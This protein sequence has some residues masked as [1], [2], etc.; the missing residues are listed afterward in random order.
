MVKVF[1]ILDGVG[2]KACRVLNGKTPLE[3]AKTKNLDFFASNGN[4]GFVYAI[5]ET[6]APESDE[7]ILALLGYDPL[8]YYYGRGPLEAYGAGLKFDEGDLV[9]R[10]NF[11]TVENGS[12]IVD[13]R[14][15]RSLTTAEA[16]ELEK[17]I[18]EKVKI[19]VP[20]YFKATIGHRGVLVL[21]GDFSD[22]ITNVDPAY[23]KK[24]KFG[25]AVTNPGNKVL[26]A[27]PL[28]P[29]KKTKM[30]ARVV[31]EFVKQSYEVL[32]D[33]PIN[34]RRKKRYL[35]P[36]NILLPRDA[37]TFLPELEARTGWT[38]V[39]AMPLEI[40]IT[41]LSGMHVL[42]FE[43]PE[44]KNNDVYAHLKKGLKLT[45]KES[46]NAIKERKFEKYFIH[47]KETDIPGHD[48][49]AKEKKKYIEMIDKKFFKYL[50]N[51]PN[52]ELVVTGDHSTPCEMK[53]H[54]KDPVPLI[55]FG[56]G[57]TDDVLRFTE[58]EC[59]NGDYGKIYGKDVLKKTGFL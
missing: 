38:A 28:D 35:L 33:H 6:I 2:D 41:K 31:N 1:V 21:K 25:V 23:V 3:A 49:R 47:F 50:R 36:A 14:V 51:I 58:A 56:R 18:N 44:V 37:G 22:N 54:S 8:K 29:D 53:G 46:I 12:K 11:S 26:E 24:G 4:G 16:L 13:R 55:H 52:L 48:N 19:E 59:M 40:G 39:V 43:Y 10:T 15:G 9:L 7:A 42:K 20:F 34:Q 5:N 17:A 45:I 57:K 30:G 27:R 32:K